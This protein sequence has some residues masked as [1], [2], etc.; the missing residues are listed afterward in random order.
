MIMNVPYDDLDPGIRR[1]V[2]FLNN[3]GFATCDS[4][5]GRSKFGLDGKPLPEW[6]SDDDR[7]EWV[8]NI[9]HVAMSCDPSNMVSECDRLRDVLLA[10][11]IKIWPMN[12]DGDT[13]SIQGS[14]EPGT[15]CYIMLI[16]ADDSMLADD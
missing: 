8:M 2:H 15:G 5:D 6:Q 14:Y 10:A 9:P 13:A 16:G 11:G 7:I 3:H 12:P 4:G 1:L